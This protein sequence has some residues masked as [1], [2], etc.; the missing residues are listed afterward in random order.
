MVES[1]TK[2]PTLV[3]GSGGWTSRPF[4]VRDVQV[5]RIRP[6]EGL[7]RKRDREGHR[8]LCR[9][10]EQLAVFTPITVRRAPDQSGDY[11]L[12]EATV[13]HSLVVCSD[14]RRFRRSS[15]AMSSPRPRRSSSPLSRTS[16]VF[17]CVPSIE[18]YSLLTH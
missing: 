6:E 13:A 5:D 2:Q 18:R 7:G 8:E 16:R 15:S 3:P 14:S 17:E 11:L 1:R 10:I 4:R 12:I 9:S